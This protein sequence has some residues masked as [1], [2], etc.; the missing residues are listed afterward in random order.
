MQDAK[1]LIGRCEAPAPVIKRTCIQ[2]NMLSHAMKGRVSIRKRRT[3]RLPRWF[4]YSVAF[5]TTETSHSAPAGTDRIHV[6]ETPDPIEASGGMKIAPHYTLKTAPR[7]KVVVI[8]AQSGD[9]QTMVDW[10]RKSAESADVVMSVCTG[11][12][13][14][15]NTGLLSG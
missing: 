14:L 12:Y 9:S 5:F 4:A 11:A 8:P 13:L 1:R 6:A 2:P 15:A 10:I 3:R 7:P